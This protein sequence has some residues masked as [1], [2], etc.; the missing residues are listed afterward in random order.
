M[1]IV[2]YKNAFLLSI[3]KNYIYVVLKMGIQTEIKE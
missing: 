2:G 1:I 3:A